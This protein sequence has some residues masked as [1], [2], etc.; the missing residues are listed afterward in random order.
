[1]LPVI[2]KKILPAL[3]IGALTGAASEG[4]SQVIKKISGK[5]GNG[6]YLQHGDQMYDLTE[7]KEGDGLLGKLLG[8]PGGKVPV[9]GDI[10]LIGALF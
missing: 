8:L 5:K 2:A 4:A 1:M 9:V 6:L 3:G 7:T 10:P